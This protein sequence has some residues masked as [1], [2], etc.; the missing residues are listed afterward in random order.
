MEYANWPFC[1]PNNTL[2]VDINM[3]IQGGEAASINQTSNSDGSKMLTVPM[4]NT[5]AA[6]IT[7]ADYGYESA[8]G[9]HKMPVSVAFKN[10]DTSNAGQTT[11]TLRMPNPSPNNTFYY[12]PT[13][14]VILAAYGRD[15]GAASGLRTTVW[16]VLGAVLLSVYMSGAGRL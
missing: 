6:N 15:H 4:T 10:R 7:F 13:V 1:G 14:T 2:S 8:N 11:V 3:N 9:T 5:T 12:D 16:A